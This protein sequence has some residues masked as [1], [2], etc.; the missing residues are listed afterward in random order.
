MYPPP[1]FGCQTAVGRRHAAAG[2]GAVLAHVPHGPPGQSDLHRSGAGGPGS[3][4]P[5][6]HQDFPSGSGVGFTTAASL[7]VIQFV[8]MVWVL[9]L[10]QGDPGR[11]A[12]FVELRNQRTGMAFWCLWFNVFSGVHVPSVSDVTPESWNRHAPHFLSWKNRKLLMKNFLE[13]R[14]VVCR[15]SS[16]DA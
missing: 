13:M 3:A 15:N 12:K 5:H 6:A 16:D 14:M 1:P 10:G 2:A 8:I 11:A 9:W 7:C 4:T